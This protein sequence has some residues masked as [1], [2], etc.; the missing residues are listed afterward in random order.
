MAHA[1]FCRFHCHFSEVGPG[2]SLETVILKWSPDATWH[3]A[4]SDGSSMIGPLLSVEQYRV[5]GPIKGMYQ[6]CTPG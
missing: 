6:S 2:Q 1:C 4:K 3:H 5:P